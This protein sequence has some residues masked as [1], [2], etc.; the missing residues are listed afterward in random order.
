M[1]VAETAEIVKSGEIACEATKTAVETDWGIDSGATH[2][3]T[4]NRPIL[5]SVRMLETPVIFGLASK[6]TV[7]AVEVGNIDAMLSRR[8]RT[9]Q[10]VYLVPTAPVSVCSLSRLLARGWEAKI[11]D[12]G[13]TLQR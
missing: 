10:N 3:L 4:P 11:R 6:G 7:E 12:D 8:R 9:L 13:G 5:K 1:E 2:H